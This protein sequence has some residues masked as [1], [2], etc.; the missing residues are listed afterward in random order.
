MTHVAWL[1]ALSPWPRDGFGL[2][3]MRALLE[4]LGDPQ[5]GLPA[6]HV[7]GTNG[8]ST[9][10]R[11]VEELLRTSGLRVGG[12][13]SPHVRS[14]AERI[15][16]DGAEADLEE[17]LAGVRPAA[18]RLEATQF[19]ALTAA[20]FVAFRAA[21]VEAAAVEAGLGG[22]HDATNVLDETRVVVLTNVSL[23]HTDVL[24]S[25]REAIAAEKLAVIH[26]GCAVVLGERE[27]EPLARA[28]GAGDVVV[29][30][31][32]STALAAAAASAFLGRPVDASGAA[33]IAL[34]GRLE[35]RPGEIRDGA[36]NPDGVRWLV[37][38]LPADDYTVM[39]SILADKD[40]DAMLAALAAAGR[41]F[42]AC[43]SS[44][45]RSLPAEDLAGRARNR[46]EVVEARD[47]PR[48]ALEL[49]HS[50]GEPVLVTGS[51]YLL[52][53]LEAG[54]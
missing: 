50:L 3:R 14:W 25:T 52:A 32:G 43:R 6:V 7:V 38:H 8:K 5:A 23:E 12:Y 16:V 37:E 34:P 4:A 42:V 17:A 53:D 15:R 30:T 46:F 19:E 47:D 22:R 9:T 44:N 49:A 24:G 1:E 10:T 41:R 11:K 26:P 36:H 39:A 54:R 18:E 27:W 29:E 31:G 20:A 13:L 33:G 48:D 21:G 35:R 40:V 2:D 51:L 28:A 45:P